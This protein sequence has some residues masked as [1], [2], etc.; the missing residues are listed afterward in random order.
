MNNKIVSIAENAAAISDRVHSQPGEYRQF[1]DRTS[2]KL[3]GFTGIWS[4]IAECAVELEKQHQQEWDGDWS[5]TC[6]A[7]GDLI[8][9]LQ[10]PAHPEQLV[11]RALE[12]QQRSRKGG[13]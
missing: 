4:L 1:Y 2:S 11:S 13:T 9:S 3:S 7:I 10:Q 5:E 12:M 8:L 6:W